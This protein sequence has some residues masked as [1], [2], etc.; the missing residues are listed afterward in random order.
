M[1]LACALSFQVCDATRNDIVVPTCVSS[2]YATQVNCNLFSGETD[3]FCTPGALFRDDADG[4]GCV[5]RQGVTSW[6]RNTL[7][8]IS[9]YGLFLLGSC[10]LLYATYRM[11]QTWHVYNSYG[12]STWGWFRWMFCGCLPATRWGSLER[13]NG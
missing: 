6:E 13:L 12:G 9:I 11:F 5:A 10:L 2:C 3:D 7:Q 8:T 1:H 4:R